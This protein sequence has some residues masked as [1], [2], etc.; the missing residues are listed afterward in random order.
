MMKKIIPL[1]AIIAISASLA[2]A[3][4]VSISVSYPTH[5]SASDGLTANYPSGT[6]FTTTMSGVGEG[7][8]VSFALDPSTGQNLAI[9]N[10]GGGPGQPFYES[11]TSNPLTS[12]T[13]VILY[14][15][16]AVSGSGAYGTSSVTTNW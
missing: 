16:L 12:S 1:M 13:T 8:G 5:P 9:T 6:T 11:H 7:G 10:T 15:H 4:T 2:W 14:V 3:T